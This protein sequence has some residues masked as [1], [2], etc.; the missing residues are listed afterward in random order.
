MAGWS[1]VNWLGYMQ[2]LAKTSG[3]EIMEK[4]YIPDLHSL[5]QNERLIDIKEICYVN[6]DG[7]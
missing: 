2:P 7:R 1:H 4:G 6:V 3:T 5:G